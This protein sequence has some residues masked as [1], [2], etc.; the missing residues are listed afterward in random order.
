MHP[1]F[2]RPVL[3][4]LR[5]ISFV[6]IVGGGKTGGGEGEGEEKTNHTTKRMNNWTERSDGKKSWS[7]LSQ[8]KI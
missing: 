2:V 3:L 4:I 1:Q 5:G 6:V 8:E 7:N